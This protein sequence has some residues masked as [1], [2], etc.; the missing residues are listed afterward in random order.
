MEIEKEVI[1]RKEL[2]NLILN[3]IEN[4][5]NNDNL[6]S[7]TKFITDNGINT[8]K[9][10]LEDL[11]CIILWIT[12]YHRRKFN[13]FD[14]I[15][16]IIEFMLP[17]IKS[18][19]SDNEIFSLFL[20]NKIIILWLLQNKIISLNNESLHDIERRL[21]INA[22][23]SPNNLYFKKKQ[24]DPYNA[25]FLYF[26]YK[27]IEN[28]EK[29]DEIESKLTKR[30][31]LNVDSILQLCQKGENDSKICGLIRNDS[32]NDFIDYTAQKKFDFDSKIPF[33]IFETNNFL[34]K[35]M[36]SLIEYAAFFGS[37]QIFKYLLKNRAKIYPNL[38]EFAIHSG[39]PEMIHLV[40]DNSDKF[41]KDVFLMSRSGGPKE[42]LIVSIRCFHNDIANY[43]LQNNFNDNSVADVD[44]VIFKT[45]FECYNYE[46]LPENFNDLYI[47]KILE[48]KDDFNAD[49]LKFMYSLPKLIIPSSIKFLYNSSFEM[50][51]NL[52]EVV[53]PSSVTSIGPN[54]FNNCWSLMNVSFL[55]P[56]S[57]RII[58]IMAFSNCVSLTE[59]QLPS[60]LESIEDG[61]F[62]DCSSLKQ[63][64]IPSSVKSIK[65]KCFFNCLSLCK[66]VF[67]D[68]SS[69]ESIESCAFGKCK[70]LKEITLPQTLTK[71][72][73]FT[74]NNCLSLVHV[75]IPSSITSIDNFAF[76]DCLSLTQIT[77]PSSVTSIGKGAFQNCSSLVEVKILSSIQ[78]I[79]DYSF[80][81]CSSLARFEIPSS[82]KS[83]GNFAFRKCAS[84][85]EITIPS[86][87]ISIGKGTFGYCSSLEQVEIPSSVIVIED[88]TFEFCTKLT[89]ISIP[90]S[91]TNIG[92]YSFRKCTSLS[93]IRI[94]SLVTSI[95]NDAF[96]ECSSLIHIELP[97]LISKINDFTFYKCTSL[98]QITTNSSRIEIGSFA[99][100]GCCSLKQM[101]FPSSILK[102]GDF[103]FAGCRSKPAKN[104]SK[105]QGKKDD[106]QKYIENRKIIYLNII[107]YLES[108][109]DNDEQL[110][111]LFKVFDKQ[112]LDYNKLDLVEILNLLSK[113]S[114]NHARTNNLIEKVE[115]ILINYKDK[116]KLNLSNNKICHIFRY[117]RRILLFLLK[118]EI[119]NMN[120]TVIN[121]ITERKENDFINKDGYQKTINEYLKPEIMKFKGQDIPELP[122]DFEEKR[123]IG[124]NDS[125]ICQII[126]NDSINEFIVYYE[127]IKEEQR[128][129]LDKNIENV[130]N[131]IY[132]TNPILFKCSFAQYAAFYGSVKIFNFM[133]KEDLNKK[134]SH[135]KSTTDFE[136]MKNLWKYAIHGNQLNII[137]F[138]EENGIIPKRVITSQ[139]LLPPQFSRKPKFEGYDFESSSDKFSIIDCFNL[140]VECHHY[141]IARYIR[142]KYCLPKKIKID[143]KY[144]NFAFIDD[145]FEKTKFNAI[146]PIYDTCSNDFP[147]FAQVF[148]ERVS[149]DFDLNNVMKRITKSAVKSNNEV[150]F[151]LAEK[152][153]NL[154][155]QTTSLF[156]AISN[157]NIDFLK[158]ILSKDN[159][160][161]FNKCKKW[162]FNLGNEELRYLSP[163]FLAILKQNTEIISLLL[164]HPSINV[165]FSFRPNIVRSTQRTA[166]HLAILLENVPIVKLLLNHPGIDLNIRAN[167][168]ES[169]YRFDQWSKTSHFDIYFTPLQEAIELE[170]VEIMKLLLKNPNISV[171][172]IEAYDLYDDALKNSFDRV[173]QTALCRA[174]QKKNYELVK[175]LL[176]HPEID[177][178]MPAIFHSNATRNVDFEYDDEDYEIG[179][180]GDFDEYE[181]DEYD[182]IIKKSPLQFAYES[183]SQEIIQLLLNRDDIKNGLEKDGKND[184]SIKV[185][186]E[187]INEKH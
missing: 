76:S 116:I 151:Y 153:P 34:N 183:R 14:K 61:A 40:E 64:S 58:G 73:Q 97:S 25:L 75:A 185:F 68:S 29:Q 63:I 180:F 52:K 110:M 48:K 174:I 109:D 93:Q 129:N 158:I 134:I 79:E 125:E 23:K 3:F 66:I 114:E 175:L 70:S 128:F 20:S 111:E 9:T 22:D 10:D 7:L 18:L 60:S 44:E 32:L 152:Y 102:V 39:N 55:D 94:P 181:I 26:H 168:D 2:E 149:I 59:I 89:K 57:L 28:K 47:Y 36:V 172:E 179:D 24:L 104:K 67:S 83:I 120:Q 46:F 144:Y 98:K 51:K 119:I 169:T 12:Y 105:I 35:K 62:K 45:S 91:V 163:L 113:I 160:I 148:M 38:L 78:S 85:T 100:Y 124:E 178:N 130:P 8:C 106:V 43:L 33:S 72:E 27:T 173:K 101:N 87:I 30:F 186:T 99:F 156:D 184:W 82:V 177:V 42:A 143:L 131:S 171:N 17:Y 5:D 166:L 15:L 150:V 147:R 176:D 157:E 71:I 65:E 37:T 117:N 1:K 142:S 162:T 145:H 53:I 187:N 182:V 167:F 159:Y 108:P 123:K 165:N 69:L 112:K 80:E 146:S 92:D 138:L 95:G 103:A 49:A 4:E 16:Q 74:F 96:S 77:I 132:E 6:Q 21:Y 135:I 170:N 136:D 122:N 161:N 155:F 11:F 118:N 50:F 133:F 56:P 86:S 121:F 127:K 19:Y 54:S 31:K 126:R 81:C 154:K 84:L 88:Y 90:S 141:E 164:N 107:N 139:D 13:F 140:A 41:E 137:H 115:K